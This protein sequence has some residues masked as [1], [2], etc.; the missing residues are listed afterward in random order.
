[1]ARNEQKAQSMLSR[2][3]SVQ[4][5]KDGD[6]MTFETMSKRKPP[7]V[8]EVDKKEVAE[9]WRAVAIKNIS[10]KMTIIQHAEGMPE[11][12]I[13]QLNDEINRAIKDKKRWEV[14]IVELG[15]PNYSVCVYACMVYYAYIYV[16]VI[17][18]YVCI[19]SVVSIN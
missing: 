3:L 9:K 6:D 16:W 12:R 17:G 1:M 2:F 4:Q 19:V 11:F 5:R 18:I 10:Q 15:G 8:E 7:P 14:R 13:R